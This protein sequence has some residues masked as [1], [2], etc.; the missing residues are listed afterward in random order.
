MCDVSYKEPPLVQMFRKRLLQYY[1]SRGIRTSRKRHHVVACFS[2]LKNESWPVYVFGI[3]PS[4]SKSASVATH[5]FRVAKTSKT[6]DMEAMWR[7][8]NV[9]RQLRG[10]KVI[11]FSLQRTSRAAH[12]PIDFEIGLQDSPW[13]QP[14]HCSI[15]RTQHS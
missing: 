3:L 10:W 9:L 13:H 1:I 6:G 14:S 11:C 2:S 15:K 8:Q 12:V 5:G 7:L 4:S